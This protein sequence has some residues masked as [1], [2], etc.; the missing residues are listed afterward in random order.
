MRRILVAVSLRGAAMFPSTL[1]YANRRQGSG[2][3]TSAPFTSPIP[4]LAVP[5]Q[6]GVCNVTGRTFM[7]TV[8]T[9]VPSLIMFFKPNDPSHIEY[10]DLVVGQVTRLNKKHS[11]KGA[12]FASTGADKGLLIK[13]GLVNVNEEKFLTEKLHCDPEK[14]IMPQ[15]LFIRSGELIDRMVGVVAESHLIEASES[16]LDYCITEM[17][18]GGRKPLKKPDELDENPMTLV[19]AGNKALKEKNSAKAKTLYEKALEM[20]LKHVVP[21]KAQLGFGPKEPTEAMLKQLRKNAIYNAAPQALSGL[22]MVEMI[23]ENRPGAY[24]I[25]KRIKEEY[26]FACSDLREVATAVARVEILVIAD[27]ALVENGHLKLHRKDTVEETGAEFYRRNLQMAADFFLNLRLP[28]GSMDLLVRLIRTEP[29][30]LPE[31]KAAG[32]VPQDTVLQ[33][34][35]CTPARKILKLIFDALGETTEEV[36][37]FR[38]KVQAII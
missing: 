12:Y 20:S 32:I 13:L 30:L 22:A 18:D 25:V 1:F 4:P 36:V 28:A 23:E 9:G 6:V 35:N 16:F 26:P 29:K 7:Q 2:Q 38:R 21:V 14:D 37:D 19:V 5:N 3:K 34:L 27:Y 31:L 24:T 11:E 10:C 33:G 15:I 8:S 17:E